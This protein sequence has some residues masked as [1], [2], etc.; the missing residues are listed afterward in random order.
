MSPSLAD[1][2]RCKTQVSHSRNSLPRKTLCTSLSKTLLIHTDKI[3]SHPEK[4]YRN[5]FYCSPWGCEYWTFI[6]SLSYFSIIV[7]E[8]V[9]EPLIILKDW[10]LF[11]TLFKVSS[12]G[13]KFMKHIV[14][15][16]KDGQV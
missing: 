11:I 15:E 8:S 1:C 12:L 13:V 3:S 5:Y 2:V 6:Y 4:Y 7:T 14:C 16:N 9:E 10:M